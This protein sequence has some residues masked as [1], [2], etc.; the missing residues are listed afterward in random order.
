MSVKRMV[1]VAVVVAS[2]LA[3]VALTGLP[4]AEANPR[5]QIADNDAAG[6]GGE[7]VVAHCF[8]FD[9]GDPQICVE[10]VKGVR[11]KTGKKGK[12]GRTG[13]TGA[14]GHIGLTGPIGPTGP[15]GITGV[16]GATGL[17]GATGATGATGIQGAPGATVVVD[18]TLVTVTAPPTG[19]PQGTEL[20][21]SVAQ[22]TDI[23][24]PEAY[25]GGVVIQPSGTEQGGDVVAEQNHFLG[26]YVSSTQVNPIPA[27]G[28]VAGTVSSTSANA[29]EAQAVVSQLSANDTVTVQAYVICGP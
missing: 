29:Y 23:N 14:I 9:A 10:L 3:T 20:T 21:P 12:T 25:G 22:C 1:Y 6:V 28:S 5:A 7:K 15:I 26:T 11:G 4:W 16:T 27:P 24:D 17:T 2:C 18:G 13:K 8:K 19:E